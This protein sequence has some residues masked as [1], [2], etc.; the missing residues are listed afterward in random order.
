[1]HCSFRERERERESRAEWNDFN[2]QVQQEQFAMRLWL[3]RRRSGMA[4]RLEFPFTV[5]WT[6]EFSCPQSITLTK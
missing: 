5:T 4:D 2:F 3:R 1:M 6:L